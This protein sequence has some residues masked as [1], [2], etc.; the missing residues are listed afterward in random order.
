MTD[1][2]NNAD[3]K[4]IKNFADHEIGA[5]A[6]FGH[7]AQTTL[8]VVK[9]WPT[10][11]SHEDKIFIQ[12]RVASL[13]FPGLSKYLST[14]K[15]TLQETLPNLEFEMSSQCLLRLHRSRHGKLQENMCRELFFFLVNLGDYLALNWEY[16]PSVNHQS[17][18]C[19]EKGFSIVHPYIY[20]SYVRCVIKNKAALSKLVSPSSSKTDSR[21]VLIEPLTTDSRDSELE[22][23]L[24]GL[25]KKLAMNMLQVG[26]VILASG[27]GLSEEQIKTDLKQ[28]N[29]PVLIKVLLFQPSL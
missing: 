2:S 5:G 6:I 8:A 9:S 17:I 11:L 19:T 26:I 7:S 13:H 1:D 16:H 3:R 18:Y 4:V 21:D 28:G 29:L 27:L 23:F 12:N 25:N 15:D 10:D 14:D 24:E 22:A 20:D